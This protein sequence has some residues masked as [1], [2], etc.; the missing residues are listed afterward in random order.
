MSIGAQ[1]P[2]IAQGVADAFED[3]EG[4]G[5]DDYDREGAGDQG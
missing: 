2:D 3:R 4:E 5:T 1:S